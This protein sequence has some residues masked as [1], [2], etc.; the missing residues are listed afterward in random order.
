MSRNTYFTSKD[1]SGNKL[2]FDLSS[3]DS[4][5]SVDLTF[6]SVLGFTGGNIRFE[7]APFGASFTAGIV[8]GGTITKFLAEEVKILGTGNFISDNGGIINLPA[9]SIIRVTINNGNTPTAFKAVCS[10][11]LYIH[12]I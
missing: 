7:N 5:K 1:S 12:D 8:E 6:E 10:L 11:T 9:N 2:E 3:E 4:S